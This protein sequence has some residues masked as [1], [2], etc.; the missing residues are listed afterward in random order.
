M[1]KKFP[2]EVFAN[3]NIPEKR[4]R[5]SLCAKETTRGFYKDIF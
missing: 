1:R 2:G 5:V 3:G 4:F